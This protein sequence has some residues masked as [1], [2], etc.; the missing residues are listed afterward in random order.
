MEGHP[1]PFLLLLG[2][3]LLP[4]CQ[5]PVNAATA[6]ALVP[7]AQLF[8][9]PDTLKVHHS[10]ANPALSRTSRI[11]CS[12]RG[13]EHRHPQPLLP[14][15]ALFSP[16]HRLT[17]LQTSCAGVHAHEH[18]SPSSLC[19]VFDFGSPFLNPSSCTIH[20]YI[21]THTYIFRSLRLMRPSIINLAIFKSLRASCSLG[22][23]SVSQP[24]YHLNEVCA[25]LA[26]LG[27]L[28][29]A[30]GAQAGLL[31]AVAHSGICKTIANN[32]IQPSLPKPHTTHPPRCSL[33]L[34]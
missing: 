11:V 20:T 33:R 2:H 3:Q 19:M 1:L 34:T 4:C 25:L 22:F 7:T 23:P 27:D 8:I 29:P 24:K 16:P 18:P 28:A 9:R 30:G 6:P 12:C 13:P 32:I 5:D 14:S 21:C 31:R 17:A 15:S 26:W 10:R